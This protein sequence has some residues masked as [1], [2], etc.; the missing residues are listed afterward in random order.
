VVERA[1]G[2]A[3]LFT[4]G[5]L[6]ALR[7]DFDFTARAVFVRLPLARAG[8]RLA[9]GFVRAALRGALADRRV[10]DFRAPL[11]FLRDA[12]ALRLAMIE[13]FRNLD[14]FA[15]SVVLSAAYRHSGNADAGTIPGRLSGSTGGRR[16]GAFPTSL[17]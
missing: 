3:G 12:A 5:A 17:A 15:I 9:R 2:A 1:A 14:S 7:V 10:A 8:L 13:S 11:T 4:R 16:P 6:L